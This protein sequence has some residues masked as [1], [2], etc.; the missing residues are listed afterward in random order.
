[1][2]LLLS[3]FLLVLLPC[4]PAQE[5][6][7]G[8]FREILHNVGGKAYALSERVIEIREFRYDGAGPAAY[9]WIDNNHIPST[10][11]MGLV[12]PD[13]SPACGTKIGYAAAGTKTVR[14]ELPED[15]PLSSK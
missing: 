3:A 10:N 5:L 11:G 6:F 4:V 14:I 15:K 1:M 9:F 2:V 13:N 12:S 7:L 8:E